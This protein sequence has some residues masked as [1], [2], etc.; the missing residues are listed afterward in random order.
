[1]ELR[2][3]KT[4]EKID[5]TK[6]LFFWEK[7]VSKTDKLLENQQK[8]KDVHITNLRGL[9]TTDVMDIKIKL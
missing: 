2:K 3:R 7:K 6:C 8:I 1:M 4:V 9:I 5:L